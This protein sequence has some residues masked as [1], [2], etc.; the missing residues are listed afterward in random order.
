[1]QEEK[2]LFDLTHAQK[3]I[4]QMEQ[5]FNGTSIAN[6]GGTLFLKQNL[7]FDVWEQ[8]INKFIEMN[9]SIRIR[10]NIID[11]V[12]M[13]YFT[14][15]KY[16]K[17]KFIDFSKKTKEDI[18]DFV[19][20]RFQTPFK[21]IDNDLFEFVMLKLSESECG[22]LIKLH[23][24]I[25][26]GWATGLL[27]SQIVDNYNKIKFQNTNLIVKNPSYID[28]VESEKEYLK[29]QKFHKDREFWLNIFRELPEALYIKHTDIGHSSKANR[30]TF[31]IDGESAK[32]I[33]NFCTNKKVSPAI[34][35]ESILAIYLGQIMGRNDITIGTA[36]LNR[37]GK[38]EKSMTGMFISTIPLRIKIDNDISF[39]EFCKKLSMV[40]MNA[41]RHQKYPFDLLIKEFREIHKV[42]QRLFDVIISYQITKIDVDDQ[43]PFES[44]WYF[45]G[46]I[47]TPLILHITD[48]DDTGNFSLHYDY[49]IEFFNKIDIVDTHTNLMKILFSCISSSEA[50]LRDIQIISEEEKIISKFNN[51]FDNHLRNTDDISFVSKNNS[52]SYETQVNLSSSIDSIMPEGQ[53]EEDLHKIF[54]RVLNNNNI[55]VNDNFFDIGGDSLTLIDLVALCKNYNYEI[56]ILDVYKYKSIREISKNIL[57]KDKNQINTYSLEKR[58][59]LDITNEINFKKKGEDLLK[60]LLITGVTGFLGAHILNNLLEMTSANIFCLVRG[61]NESESI[62][63]LKSVLEFYFG[64]K[65]YIKFE[66]RIHILNGDITNPTLISN[67]LEYDSL[68]ETIDAVFHPAGVVRHFGEFEEFE[69]INVLGT[70]NIIRFCKRFDIEM[71]HISTLSVTGKEILQ[72]K[73]IDFCEHNVDKG[74]D[75]G[76]N[77]Y[78]L[79]K[80]IAE[81]KILNEVKNGLKAVIYRVGNLTG[82]SN[83]AKFQINKN[84]NAFYS[85]TNALLHLGVI[86][87]ILQDFDLE[88]TPVDLC[89][90][91]ISKLALNTSSNKMIYHIYNDNFIVFKDF[92]TF[93]KQNGMKVDLYYENIENRSFLEYINNLNNK[94]DYSLKLLNAYSQILNEDFYKVNNQSIVSCEET[95]NELQKIGFIWPKPN[96][97][98]LHKFYDLKFALISREKST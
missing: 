17:L 70:E 44:E 14:T 39:V 63:R 5:F 53:Y 92:L 37:S 85:I 59:V 66:H 62:S 56:S 22:V 86:P 28:Y 54:T 71:H 84:E 4:Y 88:F 6:I 3:R 11:G 49:L 94:D 20:K 42:K 64:E 93:L 78:V 95:K 19:N 91:A 97:E 72:S 40:Q 83:D 24:I 43:I 96:L 81:K 52:I 61:K 35:F 65:Y 45:N 26:D 41:F 58:E 79:S 74:Q 30:N 32:K 1:M 69:K 47:E 51:T 67:S 16:K 48:R 31:I 38:K 87:S 50:N 46:H 80:H 55:S 60:T 34:L 8:A 2:K 18:H 36:V 89:S 73:R 57:Q 68:G 29:S 21:L 12:V 77:L 98:Y 9:D 13:Q 25:S 27:C 76:D 33:N 82:R 90:L 10:I 7:D 75:F 23:H 15:H